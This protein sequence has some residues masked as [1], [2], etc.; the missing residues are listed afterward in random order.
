[1]IQNPFSLHGKGHGHGG[2]I[3]VCLH[4]FFKA[5]LKNAFLTS[6][7]LV[8][9]LS[10]C[11]RCPTDLT[12]GDKSAMMEVR[13]YGGNYDHSFFGFIGGDFLLL[14]SQA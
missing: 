12:M 9:L 13:I 8:I 14:R 7:I 2:D 10:H 3:A 11:M 1:L 6:L 4:S 5:F